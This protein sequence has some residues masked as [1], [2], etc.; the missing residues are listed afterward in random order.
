[1]NNDNN[2][3]NKETNK[4]KLGNNILKSENNKLKLETNKL[5]LKKNKLKLEK[6]KLKLEQN[7]LKLKKHELKL[8]THDLGL[9]RYELELE[10]AK[11]ELEKKMHFKFI[12]E[13]N[14]KALYIKESNMHFNMTNKNECIER[15]GEFNFGDHTNTE[16][17]N[18]TEKI[19][20]E[21]VIHQPV[22]TIDTKIIQAPTIK[23]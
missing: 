11:L 7:I 4:L 9:E 15:I 19:N 16:V 13:L 6:N 22:L 21:H 23:K 18:F 14:N 2:N 20:C 10:K 8:K 5:K 3:L 12:Q 17:T 1:M